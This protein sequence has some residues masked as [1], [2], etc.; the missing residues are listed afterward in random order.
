MRILLCTI[1]SFF[2]ISC[3]STKRVSSSENQSS[4]SKE[5]FKITSVS[6][7]ETYGYTEQNPIKVGGTPSGP[8]NERRFL[9][10]L[11]GPN[12]EKVSFTRIGSCCPFKSP[13]GLMGG[14]LLDKYEVSY[15]GL[16]NPVILYINMYD[17][18]ILKA[19]K[20]FR[21]KE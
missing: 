15:E 12:G 5:P 21:H 20:G 17:K 16:S 8:E 13:N 1:I 7:D 9:N 2:I 11:T 18:D 19:P 6:D 4:N 3:S 14:G 10:A